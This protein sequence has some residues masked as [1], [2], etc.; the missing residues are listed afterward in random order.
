MDKQCFEERIAYFVS[1]RVH[2]EGTINAMMNMELVSTD[3]D[4]KTVVLAFPV[5]DW[6]LNPAGNLH[7]GM[8]ATA[9]DITMGCVSYVSQ[10]VVFTPTIQMAVNYVSGISSNDTLIVEGIC[11]HN[12]SRMSQTRAIA[13][14]KSN[15][16]VIATANGSYIMNSK[17]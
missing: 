10:D 1:Q 9:L 7:G 6:Q 13:R 16:R 11:D 2:D 8:I 15:N 3:Y 12:G 17:R 5:K 4:T 14:S